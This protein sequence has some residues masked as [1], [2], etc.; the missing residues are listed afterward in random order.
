M[1][2]AAGTI[3]DLILANPNTVLSNAVAGQNITNTTV[4]TVSTLPQKVANPLSGGGT[5]N[6]NFLSANTGPDGP[7]ANAASMTAT[8][9]IETVQYQLTVPP[10]PT[11]QKSILLQPQAPNPNAPLP[12]FEVHAGSTHIT[13]PVTIPVNAT[14]IQYS[15]E[16][17]LNFNGLSWPHV[18]VATLVPLANI[19]VVLA[20]Q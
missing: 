20:A 15:Q 10:F 5:A 9:W 16:V 8:F 14:Q 1:F 12:T 7:N 2:A 6:I 3:T 17:L 19:P 11:G 18:S 13:A 4:F